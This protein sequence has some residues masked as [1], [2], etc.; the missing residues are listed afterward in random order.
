[1][2]PSKEMRREGGMKDNVEKQNG[3]GAR[4]EIRRK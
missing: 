3:D 4:E 2:E 1:M